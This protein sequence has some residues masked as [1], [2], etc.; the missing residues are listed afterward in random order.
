MVTA[1]RS[2]PVCKYRQG[3]NRVQVTP[4]T[5]TKWWGWQCKAT[6]YCGW[7]ETAAQGPSTSKSRG[8]QPVGAR[9][10]SVGLGPELLRLIKPRSAAGAM[11]PQWPPWGALAGQVAK[12]GGRRRLGLWGQTRGGSPAHPKPTPLPP[13][14]VKE[15][16]LR[17]G[18]WPGRLT[19]GCYCVMLHKKKKRLKSNKF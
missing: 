6:T 4:Y 15:P 16:V 17:L 14:G 10:D 8:E 1:Y 12:A 19:K 9:A 11:A 3:E 18:Y 13:P 2:P 7:K 5:C